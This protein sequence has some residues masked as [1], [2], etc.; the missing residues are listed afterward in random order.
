MQSAATEHVLSEICA[1]YILGNAGSLRQVAWHDSFHY[2]NN[3][4]SWRLYN[5]G[6]G[7]SLELSQS[8]LGT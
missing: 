3:L 8:W 6:P 5:Q 1:V 7:R 2:P 4:V